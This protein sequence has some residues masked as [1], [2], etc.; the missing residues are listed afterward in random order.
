[1]ESPTVWVAVALRMNSTVG[2][3]SGDLPQHV[4]RGERG[5]DRGADPR[6]S[7]RQ[8]PPRSGNHQPRHEAEGEK[9][10]AVFVLEA[11][12]ETTPPSAISSA[13]GASAPRC[14]VPSV[15]SIR[16]KTSNTAAQT[17]PSTRSST[18]SGNLKQDRREADGQCS[19]TCPYPRAHF[20]RQERGKAGSGGMRER[21]RQAKR[22]D[23]SPAISRVSAVMTATPG[24]DRHTPIQRAAQANSKTRLKPAVARHR[25]EVEQQRGRGDRDRQ[26]R[27]SR[28]PSH[29]PPGSA[30]RG[31]PIASAAGESGPIGSG[32]AVYSASARSCWTSAVEVAM[33]ASFGRDATED[34]R[35]ADCEPAIGASRRRARRAR[36]DVHRDRGEEDERVRKIQRHH[37]SVH[38]DNRHPRRARQR[39]L[40]VFDDRAKPGVVRG[41]V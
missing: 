22:D 18:Q 30:L 5:R 19:T 39:A 26:P 27:Q 20:P 40:Q 28:Q 33:K 38:Q 41:Q 21:G 36:P 37:M 9:E 1:M 2:Q 6:P 3:P 4:G 7:C 13:G 15:R 10:H 34:P 8:L 25:G 14:S 24:D 32:G 23:E 35:L 11:Q 17:S 31:V 12:A 29:R 16:A